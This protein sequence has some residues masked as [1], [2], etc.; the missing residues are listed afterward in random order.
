MV[1]GHV[2]AKGVGVQVPPPTPRE[3]CRYRR[4]RRSGDY[5]FAVVEDGEDMESGAETLG[6]ALNSF[7][8]RQR[9]LPGDAVSCITD[10]TA[11]KSRCR[12]SWGT[13]TPAFAKSRTHRPEGPVV[14][15]SGRVACGDFT[16]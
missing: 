7:V 11:S 12:A 15:S 2:P 8:N 1:E 10:M 9:D 16:A 5:C 14:E 6:S 3:S 4:L 13:S